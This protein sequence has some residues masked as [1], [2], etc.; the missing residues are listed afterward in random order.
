VRI[1]EELMEI[2]PNEVCDKKNYG[3][4]DANHWKWVDGALENMLDSLPFMKILHDFERVDCKEYLKKALPNHTILSPPEC[5]V[6]V[7]YHLARTLPHCLLRMK[8][9][10]LRLAL[11][12]VHN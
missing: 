9:H 1:I 4:I 10:I 11:L 2:W 3:W 5:P 8:S 12:M 6:N 7:W